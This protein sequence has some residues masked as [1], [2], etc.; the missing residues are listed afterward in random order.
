[1]MPAF[2][3]LS[4][5]LL[6][7]SVATGILASSTFSLSDRELPTFKS[8]CP[9]FNGT[10]VID[11]YKLYP[12]NADFDFKKCLLYIGC[13]WNATFPGI[14]HNS[15]YHIGGVG[16]DQAS[17]LLSIVV[18]AADAF[19]TGGADISGTNWIM[20]WDP[21]SK[22]VLY[23]VNLTDTAHGKYGGYQDVEQDPEGNMYVVGTYP[24]SILKVSKDGRTVTPWY[25]S[26]PPAGATNIT[27][28]AG[29]AAKGWTLLANDNLGGAPAQIVKFNMHAKIGVPVP[30]PHYPNT[31]I[32]ASDAIY[33]PPRYRGTVLLVAEDTEGIS[34]LRSKDGKWDWAEYL[35]RI[36]NPVA[37]SYATAPI[38]VGD[39]LYV[40]AIPV[41]DVST[42][43]S[44]SGNRTLFE[45]PDITAQVDNLLSVDAND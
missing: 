3:T 39:A 12:E 30:V 6:G 41:G 4:K 2:F 31:T 8:K 9:P 13:L 37:S 42:L 16:V 24:S 20:Q 26:N 28:Y 22:S 44:T 19:V 40:V 17:G 27:G 29:L 38:Q 7:A 5:L 14:S 15:D 23:K 21:V 25:L 35:G 45:F 33:L 10:F 34:V 43:G 32:V 1:M 36:P 18:D 11:Q